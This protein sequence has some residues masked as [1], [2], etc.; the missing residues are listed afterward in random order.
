MNITLKQYYDR[1]NEI[2]KNISDSNFSL[3][4]LCNSDNY[5][6]ELLIM[7]QYLEDT[8]KIIK[9]TKKKIFE[10]QHINKQIIEIIQEPLYTENA[11][12]NKDLF[13]NDNKKIIEINS[14]EEIP[15]NPLYW[16]KPLKQYAINIGGL[17]LRGNIGTIYNNNI[18]KLNKNIP[19]LIYCKDKNTCKKI[20]SGKLCKYYHDPQEL[21]YLKTAGLITSNFMELQSK[22]R[23][24]INTSWI[25]TEYPENSSNSNMRH[26]GSYDTLVEF[27]QLAKLENNPNIN[28]K[29]MNYADQCIHDILVMYSL[30]ANGLYKSK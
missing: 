17:I 8:I 15:E 12:I 20:L 29:Y 22:S 21:Y 25:Y 6:N 14:I 19:N 18:T 27:I 10:Q 13:P 28:L 16:I 4:N 24:F 30:Y 26:F 5:M 1:A 2:Q 3:I 23:N 7:E 11:I 9:N